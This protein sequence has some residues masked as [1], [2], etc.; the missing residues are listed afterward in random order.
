MILDTNQHSVFSLNYHIVF[1][2]KYRRKV[3]DDTVSERL[4]QIFE[5]IGEPYKI[6]L[7]E[8]EHDK[9]HIYVLI[10]AHPKTELSKFINAYKSAFSRL[11]KKEFP[12]IKQYLW[13]EFF[14]SRSFLLLT[15]GEA[16]IEVVKKYIQ[17][18]G[19]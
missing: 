11:I 17:N 15:V 14:W 6:T 1:C 2:V 12:N 10:K 18:Q 3:I 16:P 8:F 4:K 5:K 19:E 9:D 13:K 7:V